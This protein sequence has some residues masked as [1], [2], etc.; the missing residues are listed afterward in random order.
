MGVEVRLFFCLLMSFDSF[1]I[2]G[3]IRHALDKALDLGVKRTWGCRERSILL[4]PIN[5]LALAP[6]YGEIGIV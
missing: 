5:I 3:I 1:R 4:R 2:V 6:L